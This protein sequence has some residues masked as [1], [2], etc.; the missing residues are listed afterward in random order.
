M[1]RRAVDPRGQFFSILIDYGD[2]LECLV[3][4]GPMTLQS[5]RER[6]NVT[7]SAARAAANIM[8]KKG[9][10]FDSVVDGRPG[11]CAWPEQVVTVPMALRHVIEV[12]GPPPWHIGQICYRIGWRAPFIV[13]GAKRLLTRGRAERLEGNLWTFDLD[14]LYDDAAVSAKAL[15]GLT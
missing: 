7:E 14:W 8:V 11:I 12:G 15:G 5:I 2:A 1:A 6:Y 9:W 13:H 4:E 3:C 10:A